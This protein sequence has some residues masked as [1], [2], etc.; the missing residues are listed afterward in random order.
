MRG[1]TFRRSCASSGNFSLKTV[2]SPIAL[3]LSL[4]NKD[5]QLSGLAQ[6]HNG[7]AS[8][9]NVFDFGTALA[10]DDP[11]FWVMT[12]DCELA[13]FVQ[14]VFKV[15]SMFRLNALWS[16]RFWWVGRPTLGMS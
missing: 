1:K 10:Q 9:T 13:F 11:C 6:F 14:H 16:Y 2:R 5:A 8:P 4:I 7:S 12:W 15:V 3:L